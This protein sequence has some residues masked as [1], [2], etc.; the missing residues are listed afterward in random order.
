M[1]GRAQ[2]QPNDRDASSTSRVRLSTRQ[3]SR[4]TLI[5]SIIAPTD[6]SKFSGVSP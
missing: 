4:S 3:L 2:Q 6:T 5:P 1:R